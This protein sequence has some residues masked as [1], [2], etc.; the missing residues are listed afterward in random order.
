MTFMADA[1]RKPA[2]VWDVLFPLTLRERENRGP[3]ARRARP[4]PRFSCARHDSVESHERVRTFTRRRLLF[5]SPGERVRVT[6]NAAMDLTNSST[7]KDE[8]L[9]NML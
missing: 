4:S 8:R 2:T 1:S 9:E 7:F 5:L 3:V 6:G